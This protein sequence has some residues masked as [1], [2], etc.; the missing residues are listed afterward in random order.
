MWIKRVKLHLHQ[1]QTDLNENTQYLNIRKISHFKIS[2]TILQVF[3]FQV[4]SVLVAKNHVALETIHATMESAEE[5]EAEGE[6]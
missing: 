1:S 3:I 4:H 5:V 6:G 2:H